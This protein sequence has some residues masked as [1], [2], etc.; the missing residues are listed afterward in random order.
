MMLEKGFRI[1][2]WPQLAVHLRFQ[3]DLSSISDEIRMLQASD[4]HLCSKQVRYEG[5][6]L[7]RQSVALVPA[8]EMKETIL[9]CKLCI[10]TFLQSF[11]GTWKPTVVT[12][13][14]TTAAT[15]TAA[16]YRTRR[17]NPCR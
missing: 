9:H 1:P 14:T 10:V 8:C 5:S 17:V 7:I 6:E 4:T 16:T 13:T 15:T 3:S 11:T 12:T 2:V